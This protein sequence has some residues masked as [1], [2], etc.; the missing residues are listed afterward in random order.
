MLPNEEKFSSCW[1]FELW[2]SANNNGQLIP[3]AKCDE[4]VDLMMRWADE[5][6]FVIGVG[7]DACN[8]EGDDT[9]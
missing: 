4:L 8:P 9:N 1:A 6:D 5:N 7:W 3:S 2:L